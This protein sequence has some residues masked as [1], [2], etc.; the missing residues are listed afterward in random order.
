MVKASAKGLFVVV[1]GWRL[2]CFARN[3]YGSTP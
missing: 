2:D 3:R 1:A